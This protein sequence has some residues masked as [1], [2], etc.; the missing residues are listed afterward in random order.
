MCAVPSV[1]V[2]FAIVA[3]LAA[4]SPFVQ[5]QSPSS[6]PGQAVGPPRDGIA[7]SQAPPDL[8]D[9]VV[10]GR[11]V[12][13]AGAPIAGAAVRVSG[14][15]PS[16][17]V[18]TDAQGRFE[19][20]DVPGMSGSLMASRQG[21]VGRGGQPQGV[22]RISPRTSDLIEGVEIVLVRT[23]V[24]VGRVLGTDGEPLVGARVQAVRL[25]RFRGQRRL[26]TDGARADTTDDRGAYRLHGL[27]PGD[28]YVSVIPPHAWHL[29]EIK[30][31]GGPAQ[32]PRAVFHPGV[33]DVA[34]AR[35]VTVVPTAE[36]TAD[37][38]VPIV[39]LYS[40]RGVVIDRQG[41]PVAGAQVS[42][43]PRDPTVAEASVTSHRTDGTVGE[44][45]LVRVPAGSYA[46]VARVF[47]DGRVGGPFTQPPPM[48]QAEVDVGGDVEGLVIRITD[49]AT[50]RGRV[51]FV[52]A[53]PEDLSS[54]R[55]QASGLD[56]WMPA[57]AD[58]LLD[59]EASF[60]LRGLK[61]VRVP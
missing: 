19:L 36:T 11:V 26:A 40:V 9:A 17:A 28:C 13:D 18:L 37:V 30:S 46:I 10:R 21:Y 27:A 42:L 22:A 4:A 5:A 23:G 55:V 14:W 60:E 35:L 49:G 47:P 51:R 34:N 2:A 12:D 25:R 50:V 33:V 29:G 48:G 32:G 20:R 44:F 58:D 8:G 53:A 43:Q 7:T 56:P 1:R 59:D 31:P 16:L 61:A 45:T 38:T 3:V 24:I 57:S 6:R 52:P 54:V 39:E 15:Q 41:K